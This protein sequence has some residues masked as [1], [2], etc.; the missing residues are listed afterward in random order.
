MYIH[1]IVRAASPKDKSGPDTDILIA[2]SLVGQKLISRH[3]SR[4]PSLSFSGLHTNKDM[5]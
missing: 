2:L 1:Y 4:Q 3:K 5:T